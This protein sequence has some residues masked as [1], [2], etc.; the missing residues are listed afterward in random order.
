M[1]LGVR[2][3]DIEDFKARGI[4]II[5][6]TRHRDVHIVPKLTGAPG[7]IELTYENLALLVAAK[8]VFPDAEITEIRTKDSK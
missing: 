1:P 7:R 5:L 3:A 4:E 8:L 2:Q 6:A